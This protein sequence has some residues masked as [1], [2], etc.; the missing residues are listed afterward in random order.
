MNSRLEAL[1]KKGYPRELV[2]ELSSFT[3]EELEYIK[4]CIDNN[5]KPKIYLEILGTTQP[6]VWI[7]CN[8]YKED[9][10]NEE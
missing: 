2:F 9:N 4:Q 5:I 10:N 1:I 3:D 8:L 7:G 6:P